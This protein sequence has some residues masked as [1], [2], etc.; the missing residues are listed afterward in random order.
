MG[1]PRAG[2]ER[3][4]DQFIKHFQLDLHDYVDTAFSAFESPTTELCGRPS[5][6]VL[7]IATRITEDFKAL[8]ESNESLCIPPVITDY[9]SIVIIVQKRLLGFLCF[10]AF[11]PK[12]A[13][14]V[15]IVSVL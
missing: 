6:S 2:I 7:E 5:C 11:P 10:F 3:F 14:S 8:V 1:R 4:Q 9:L 12:F 15:A 13:L